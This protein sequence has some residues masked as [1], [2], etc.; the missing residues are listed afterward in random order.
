[1]SRICVNPLNTDDHNGPGGDQFCIF[2]LRK[3]GD[4]ALQMVDKLREALEHVV[5]TADDWK[6]SLDDAGAIATRALATIGE[7]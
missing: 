2:C 3:R 6:G 4:D 1:M 7:K 5:E